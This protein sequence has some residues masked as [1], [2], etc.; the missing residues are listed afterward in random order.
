LG[1]DSIRTRRSTSTTGPDAAGARDPM[2]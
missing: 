1:C 2:P